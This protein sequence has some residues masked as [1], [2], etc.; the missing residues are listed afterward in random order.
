MGFNLKLEVSML[1]D[2]LTDYLNIYTK[3]PA[4]A[5]LTKIER[6]ERYEMVTAWEAQYYKT[7]PTLEEALEFM[8]QNIHLKYQKPF[9]TKVVF[10]QI[11]DDI[12]SEKVDGIRFLFDYQE[13]Y[14]YSNNHSVTDLINTFCYKYPKYDTVDLATK[15][16][17]VEPNH[18]KA[19]AHK[20]RLLQF[21]LGF[22]IH[23]MPY[24]ILDGKNLDGTGDMAQL[25]KWLN[26]F[27][28]I[29]KKLGK[30]D[31]MLIEEC[32]ILFPAWEQYL[33][34]LIK[35]GVDC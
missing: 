34:C 32:T 16:L 2:V 6:K 33:D 18:E 26:D 5:F 13:T 25:Y 29:S 35:H 19:M 17:T 1:P 4:D 31:K 3:Y 23:T 27:T 21:W 22:S 14:S 24:G 8:E 15:L 11:K 9:F 28:E 10:P 30:D 20:Y 7:M 12:E